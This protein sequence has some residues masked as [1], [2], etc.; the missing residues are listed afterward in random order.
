ML[1][2]FLAIVILLF[3]HCPVKAIIGISCPG[4]G[5]T[6]ALKSALCLNFYQAFNYHPLFPLTIVELI[7]LFFRKSI[8]VNKKA[9]LTAGIITLF[10]FLV[11]W[12]FREFI[13]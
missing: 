2:F 13:L 4:C 10:L 3:Y 1:W 5:M 7:Y 11:V 12:I 9:E 6:R 8:K